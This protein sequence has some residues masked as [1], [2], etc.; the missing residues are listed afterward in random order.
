MCRDLLACF[1]DGGEALDVFYR[2][3]VWVQPFFC[4]DADNRL[5]LGVFDEAGDA[6]QYGKDAQIERVAGAEEVVYGAF[7]FVEVFVHGGCDG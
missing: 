5:F 6:Q 4:K 1:H 7:E 2:V 3:T